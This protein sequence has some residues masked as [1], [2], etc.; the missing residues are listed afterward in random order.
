VVQ[1]FFSLA[2]LC[3]V[4]AL[5]NMDGINVVQ[6]KTFSASSTILALLQ[7]TL[8]AC[9]WNTLPEDIFKFA[10][11]QLWAL[12][13]GSYMEHVDAQQQDGA[14]PEYGWYNTRFTK[15]V[16]RRGLVLWQDVRK[17]LQTIHHFDGLRPHGSLWFRKT[18]DANRH[19]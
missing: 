12:Y 6:V 7:K 11:I 18:M 16:R 19:P 3:Y 10:N 4:R 1:D 14:R 9:E 5:M 2:A 8:V 17:L 15:H 13:F